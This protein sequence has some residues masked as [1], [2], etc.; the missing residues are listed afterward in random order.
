MNERQNKLNESQ[1]QQETKKSTN[2]TGP[3]E[4]SESESAFGTDGN[5]LDVDGIIGGREAGGP[6]GTGGVSTNDVGR[7]GPRK[8]I[9]VDRH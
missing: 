1:R 8:S 6:A 7:R 2:V 9:D 3:A 4:T 5:D